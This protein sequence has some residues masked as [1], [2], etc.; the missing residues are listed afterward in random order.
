MSTAPIKKKRDL[1]TTDDSR[2]SMWAFV[3]VYRRYFAH[4]KGKLILALFLYF[5]ACSAGYVQKYLQRV[6]VDYVLEVKLME[7]EAQEPGDLD[8]TAPM[9]P[10]SKSFRTLG[11][12]ENPLS[13]DQRYSNKP[14]K[15]SSEKFRL[16]IIVAVTMLVFYVLNMLANWHGSVNIY[17]EAEEAIYELRS[18]LHR[19][20]L[21]LPMRFYDQE[22]TGKLVS[23]LIN[24]VNT[25]RV[26]FA[27][28]FV[29]ILV[30]VF[31]LCIGFTFIYMIDWKLALITT[32]ILPFYVGTYA[33]IRPKVRRLTREIR[34]A[35]ASS[36]ALIQE[37]LHGIRAVKTFQQEPSE[38]RG[39]YRRTREIA[40][41][42][43][44]NAMLNSLMGT[45]AIVIN[46]VGI[47]VVFWYGAIK[48]RDGEMTLGNLLLFYGTVG[49]LYA[50]LQLLTNY[51][52]IVQRMAVIVERIMQLMNADVA[53]HDDPDA[54]SIDRIEGHIRLENVG[55]VYPEGDTRALEGIDLDIA[56]GTTLCVMGKSGSGK[57]SL[58]A[59][60]M[61]LY[62]V[63]EGRVL[64]DGI[65]IRKIK[66]ADLRSRISMVGQESYIF[67]GTIAENIR[68]GNL[69]ATPNQ[70]MTAAKQA[71][72]HDYILTLPT[73]Y[74]TATEEQG[75]NLSG[76]QKQRISLARALLTNPDV[77]ILDD[78]TSAL[79][80]ATTA[81][82]Q[83]TLDHVMRD[84]TTIVITHRVSMAMKCSRIVVLDEGRVVQDGTHE[85]LLEQDGFYREVYD[86]QV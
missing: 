70:I 74:E 42:G 69:E 53:I 54:V 64:V 16:L 29:S 8:V 12:E 11:R 86:E 48:V 27:Q 63:T 23:R 73:K 79:D 44:L 24:D 37:K 85:E 20:L 83:E 17:L 39:F 32:C 51:Q 49:M 4:R 80:M 46:G 82:I 26:Q 15:T 77:L 75:S 40:R 58:A 22:E 52:L 35:F 47:T 78:C 33:S 1:D 62:D 19:R 18:D 21:Q 34:R 56:P 65:D 3:D 30:H 81:R 68:Y 55:L 9:S 10:W 14:G 25:I 2:G 6:M 57:S 72:I 76:G 60:L 38:I 50:P 66:L 43:A 61:R 5:F 28:S 71:E 13:L 59:A 31:S 67:R 84:R 7:P 45:L 36:Y 41:K